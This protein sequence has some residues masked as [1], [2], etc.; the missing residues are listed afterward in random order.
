MSKIILV[1]LKHYWFLEQKDVQTKRQRNINVWI[2]E[3]INEFE[4]KF[5]PVK[6][7][8]CIDYGDYLFLALNESEH[9]TAFAI[10]VDYP[11]SSWSIWGLKNFDQ[12]YLEIALIVSRDKGQGAVLIN[13]IK[14]FCKSV[15]LRKRIEVSLSV[16]KLQSYYKAHGFVSV[17]G[18]KNS[19][20]MQYRV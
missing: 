16:P 14:D 7:R 3:V 13:E 20:V 2:D 15:L 10:C 4:T 1:P 11:S 17:R 8:H 18:K 6:T 5:D 12:G 19:S 9:V